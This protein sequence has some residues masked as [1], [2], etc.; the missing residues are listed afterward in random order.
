MLTNEAFNAILKTLEEPPDHAVFILATTNPE[1]IPETIISR[2]QIIPFRNVTINTII[3]HLQMIT[4]EESYTVKE[5]VFSYIAKRAKGSMRDA[6]VLL[7]QVLRFLPKETPIQKSDILQVLGGVGDEHYDR[8]IQLIKNNETQNIIEFSEHLYNEGVNFEVFLDGLTD[9][10]I[11]QLSETDDPTIQKL[12][13]RIAKKA[14]EMIK[15]IKYSDNPNIIFSVEFLSFAEKHSLQR[16]LDKRKRVDQK[17]ELIETR[18]PAATP[19]ENTTPDTSHTE[20][21]IDEESDLDR[22]LLSEIKSTDIDLYFALL[23]LK[24]EKPTEGIVKLFKDDTYPFSNYVIELKEKA[25]RN[26]MNNHTLKVE[27]HEDTTESVQ[28]IKPI[29]KKVEDKEIPHEVKGIYDKLKR[30][31]PESD[32]IIKDNQKK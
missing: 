16:P 14:S 6:I 12:K 9:H 2:C 19:T 13:L 17:P 27:I 29:T 4:K 28:P 26:H 18:R 8:F 15:Q 24:T 31:F 1:K 32:V 25:L 7:E 10:I 21:S 3:N 11:L 23:Y 22:D 5:D 20:T 30:L